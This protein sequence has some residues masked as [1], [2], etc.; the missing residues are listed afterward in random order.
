MKFLTFILLYLFITNTVALNNKPV[1]GVL[2]Y[3]SDDEKLYPK[4]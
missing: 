4:N 3:P 2:S 1:I